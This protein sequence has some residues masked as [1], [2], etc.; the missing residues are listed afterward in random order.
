MYIQKQTL[1]LAILLISSV[2]ISCIQQESRFTETVPAITPTAT[3]VK[4]QITLFSNFDANL[5]HGFTLEGLV[6]PKNTTAFFDFDEG[7]IANTSNADIYL[8]VGCGTDCFNSLIDIN[9][10]KSVEV[11]RAEPNFDGCF[12]ALQEDKLR[13]SIVPGTYSCIYTN[14]GNIVQLFAIENEARSQNSKFT[15]EYIIWYQDR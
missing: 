13:A 11:G 3:V 7:E 12:N 2:L 5:E 4:G 15:F 10:S 8:S 6:D 1:L 14:D 9:G